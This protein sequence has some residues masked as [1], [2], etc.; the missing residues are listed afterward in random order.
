[1]A[2]LRTGDNAF[3]IEVAPLAPVGL[4]ERDLQLA[5]DMAILEAGVLVARDENIDLLRLVVADGDGAAGMGGKCVTHFVGEFR[6]HDGIIAS[7]VG[8]RSAR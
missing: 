1:M 2:R 5:T 6:G 8:N 4:V 3:D 7:R